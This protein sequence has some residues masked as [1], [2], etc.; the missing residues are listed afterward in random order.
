MPRL[1]QFCEEAGSSTKSSERRII[2]ISFQ[3]VKDPLIL[4]VIYTDYTVLTFCRQLTDN[5]RRMNGSTYHAHF[6][7]YRQ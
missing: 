1:Y 5:S 6:M 3:V 4:H 2:L 7:I